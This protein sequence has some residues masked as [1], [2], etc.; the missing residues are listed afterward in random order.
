MVHTDVKLL[1]N[2]VLGL[3]S[4]VNNI[5]SMHNISWEKMQTTKN[6][7]PGITSQES[8]AQRLLPAFLEQS[9]FKIQAHDDSKLAIKLQDADILQIVN[10][11]KYLTLNLHVLFL[12]LPLILAELT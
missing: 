11:M 7:V 1:K 5:D 4:R 12:S 3:L 6:K 8:Q 2:T 9:S 10:S